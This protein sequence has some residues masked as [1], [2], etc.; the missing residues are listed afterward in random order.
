MFGLGRYFSSITFKFDS[1]M[2]LLVINKLHY[3]GWKVMK[4]I[5][6]AKL[7]IGCW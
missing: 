1:L 7:H 2:G 3:A 6:W 5:T 4:L